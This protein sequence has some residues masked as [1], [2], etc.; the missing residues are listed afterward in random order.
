MSTASSKVDDASSE[1]VAAEDPTSKSFQEMYYP[2]S[3]SYINKYDPY[4]L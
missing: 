2:I 3:P 1:Q 4:T